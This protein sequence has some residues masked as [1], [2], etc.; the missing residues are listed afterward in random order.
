M[1]NETLYGYAMR[2]FQFLYNDTLYMYG[3]R[4]FQI[5]YRMYCLFKYG[6]ADFF[7]SV[8]IEI[9][10]YCNR[11]CYYCPNS[12]YDTPREYMSEE[13]FKKIIQN[14]KE[15][16][17]KGSVTYEL[18]GEPLL[19]E[20]LVDFI[21][22]S[23]DNLPRGAFLKVLSNGDE[24]TMELFERLIDAGMKEILITLHDLDPTSMMKKLQPMIDKHPSHIRLKT[25]HN[26]SY[27]L[28]RGG[29]IEIHGGA[30]IKKCFYL[31]CAVI[32]YEGN[33]ILCCNDYLH[34]HKFGNVREERI[35]DIWK[36]KEFAKIRQQAR[37]GRPALEICRQCLTGE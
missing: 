15:V 2:V 19:D 4:A 25:I 27:L 18:Y 31:S 36:K 34:A 14:L 7:W 32:D 17:Y 20:R 5:L 33:V 22:Y 11:R 37:K 12:R 10:T 30:K 8:A 1:G 35:E 26:S 9:S 24:L 13:L 16:G 21:R 28:N 29:A 3:T 6:Y 23:R